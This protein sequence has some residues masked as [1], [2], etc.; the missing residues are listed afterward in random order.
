MTEFIQN[1]IKR[2]FKNFLAFLAFANFYAGFSANNQLNIILAAGFT[3]SLI[4]VFL[5]PFLKMLFLPINVITL[6]MFNWLIISVHLLLVTYI[7]SSLKFV[8][9]HYDT[10]NILG[11][12]VPGGD[13]N[14]LFSVIIGSIFFNFIHKGIEF[15]T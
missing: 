6:G 2:W 3:L 14:L 5:N 8:P 4:Q 13:I 7:I 11:L 12:A 1:F 9:F 15:L 10:F